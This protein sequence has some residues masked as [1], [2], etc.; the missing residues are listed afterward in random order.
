VGTRALAAAALAGLVFAAPALGSG[1][2]SEPGP[3]EVLSVRYAFS[4]YANTVRGVPAGRLGVSTLR[5]SATLK[6]RDSV[7]IRISG[8]LKP[9]S[10]SKAAITAAG[11]AWRLSY[12]DTVST[13]VI[14]LLVVST[15]DGS[16][17]P[18]GARGSVTLVDD[19]ARLANGKTRDSV[20]LRFRTGACRP[21]QRSW[22]NEDSVTTAPPRGGF[23]GGQR[24]RVEITLQLPR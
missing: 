23:G 16:V 1:S 17:C 21:L 24:A 5:G 2:R 11:T 12:V 19:D 15:T 10:G 20:R 18:E 7:P 14:D 22:T 13:L 6:P 4:A 3:I 9:P 8:T